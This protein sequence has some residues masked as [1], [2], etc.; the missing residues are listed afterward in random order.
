MRH[1]IRLTLICFGLAGAVLS[2]GAGE[3][4]P[5]VRGSWHVLRQAHAGHP[6]IV[7]FW[8]LSCGPCLVELPEWGKLAATH[9]DLTLVLVNAD[10][11][12]AK[13]DARIA[14]T[15]QNAGL[16]RAESWAFADRFD[17]RLRYEI[18]PGWQGD[19]PRTLLVDRDGNVTP[20]SGIADMTHVRAWVAGPT[21]SAP[22]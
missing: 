5:F 10:R 22:R 20:I 12:G 16:G 9:P 14:T 21:Q 2:A 1:L 13:P 7:H 18:E 11:P 19:M 17:E 4:R 6:A 3:T 8:G 15:L